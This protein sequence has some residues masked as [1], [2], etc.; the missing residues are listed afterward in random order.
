M[1]TVQRCIGCGA[2]S[3][4]QP[5]LGSCVDR[6]LDLV[7]ASEHADAAAAVA[8]LEAAL[9]ERR[10]L[11]GRLALAPLPEPEWKLLQERARAALRAPAKP[12]SA[13][14]VTAWACETCG[15]IEAPQECIG[16]CVRPE[17]AM[18]PAVEHRATIARAASLARALATLAPPLRQLAWATPRPGQ[19]AHSAAAL[20]AA[21]ERALS[22]SA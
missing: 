10:S 13:L 4:P 7:A 20:R 16:V 22:A 6:R 19:W 5:C 17:I 2:I 21:A 14:E 11:V 9:V 3:T 15:R 1:I 12:A 18:V 8:A